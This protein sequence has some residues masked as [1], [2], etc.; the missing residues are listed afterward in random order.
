MIIN[1]KKRL[2]LGIAVGVLLLLLLTPLFLLLA[3]SASSPCVLEPQA[4]D[5]AAAIRAKQLALQL[6]HDI[7]SNLPEASLTISQ[8]DINGL[9]AIAMRGTKR[10]TGRVNVT[11]WTIEAAAA[12]HVPENPL[13]AYL[14]IRFGV[15]PSHAGLRLSHLAI[16]SLRFSG[17]TALRLGELLL[18][19]LAG[20][21]LG[22]QLRHS[23]KSVDIHDTEITVVYRPIPDL[24]DRLALV[25]Q[26]AK[27]VRD[28][29]AL[30][31]DPAVV[32]IYYRELCDFGRTAR[33][34]KNVSLGYYLSSAFTLAAKRTQ[35]LGTEPVEEN[36]A[37]LLALAIYLGS[38]RFEPLVGKVRTEND[39]ACQA[40]ADNITLAQRKDLRLHFIYSAAFKL[41][42]DS[43][44]SFALGEFK[45]MMDSGRGGSG[46]SFVDL[47][48]DRTGIRFAETALDTRGGARR[49][50][51][52]A[53]G[54]VD[55]SRFFPALTGLPE[56]IPQAE[57]DRRYGGIDGPLYQ[58]YI[59]D[60]DGRIRRKALY[61]TAPN[62]PP[63]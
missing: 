51:E 39:A 18:N 42:A 36:R 54:L 41:M 28:N 19:I 34:A 24:K 5:T 57:F 61:Q 63:A 43:G 3:L 46:F 50:Q 15:E 8:H 26:R 49:L 21:E 9:L 48:A 31:G 53:A 25:K 33:Q 2:F 29:L 17:E 11:P 55:E 37:A 56:D 13:G 27:A 22:S 1:S 6:R 40:Y 14:N 4:A 7:G 59:R 52:N 38:E 23:V 16:G 12:F 45:E 20:N 44:V 60:I 30:L 58:R 35:L 32:R 62:R 47:T 10:F